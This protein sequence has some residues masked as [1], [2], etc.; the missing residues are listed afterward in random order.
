MPRWSGLSIDE[1][2]ELSGAQRPL[3]ARVTLD[4]LAR[5]AIEVSRPTISALP[6]GVPQDK[7]QRKFNNIPRPLFFR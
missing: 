6:G 2:S 4:H 5:Q 3:P 7:L 1:S